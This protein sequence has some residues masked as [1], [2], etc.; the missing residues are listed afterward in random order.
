MSVLIHGP[1]SDSDR[2]GDLNSSIC[3]WKWKITNYHLIAYI[4]CLSSS[5]VITENQK[6]LQCG[7]RFLIHYTFCTTVLIYSC[8]NIMY[9][10]AN[11][12]K[13]GRCLAKQSRQCVADHIA[14]ISGV[15]ICSRIYSN[16]VPVC[17]K[18]P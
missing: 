9:Y 8:N 18:A 16:L 1:W 4:F 7:V 2:G 6:D 13:P 15:I 17:L 5:H 11:N 12:T 10:F 3:L 14:R